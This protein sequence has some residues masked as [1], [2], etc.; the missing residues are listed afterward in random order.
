VTL[1]RDGPEV[2]PTGSPAGAPVATRTGSGSKAEDAAIAPPR[3]PRR[4]GVPVQ[5]RTRPR[6]V[7]PPAS[8]G[9]EAPAGVDFGAGSRCPPLVRNGAR[10]DGAHDPLFEYAEP[11]LLTKDDAARSLSISVR[12]LSRFLADG[13]LTAVRLGPRLVRFTTHD[14]AAFVARQSRQADPPSWPERPQ[15]R[16]H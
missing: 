11:L 10:D 15:R 16:R 3:R 12:Q 13:S 4:G 1:G 8:S 6:P 5:A 2:A 14:L 7:P 9:A